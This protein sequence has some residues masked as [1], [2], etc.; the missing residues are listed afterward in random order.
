M[1][2]FRICIAALVLIVFTLTALVGTT[3]FVSA[4][5]SAPACTLIQADD[6]TAAKEACNSADPNSVCFGSDT[7]NVKMS[8]SSDFAK[9]GDQADLSSIESIN[10]AISDP[11]SGNGG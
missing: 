9:Q 10:T 4:E 1:R 2:L 6:L 3:R 11:A 5:E 8:G 7:I